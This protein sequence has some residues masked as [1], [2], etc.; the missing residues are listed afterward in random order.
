MTTNEVFETRLEKIWKDSDPERDDRFLKKL[1]ELKKLKEQNKKEELLNIERHAALVKKN[2][3]KQLGT[4][5]KE[6]VDKMKSA[7]D[8]FE[9]GY[10]DYINKSLED[11]EKEGKTT[12]LSP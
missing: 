7:K 5:N 1:D 4:E 8:V 11:Y 2:M 9:E 6:I 3:S 12:L 10:N